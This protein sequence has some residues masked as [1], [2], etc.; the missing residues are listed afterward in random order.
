VATLLRVEGVVRVL[1]FIPDPVQVLVVTIR[2]LLFSHHNSVVV[3]YFRF[4]V[5]LR[6]NCDR[7]STSLLCS[8]IGKG[9]A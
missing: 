6:R 1:V 4:R 2:F 7:M 5:C 9:L 3:A 8:F